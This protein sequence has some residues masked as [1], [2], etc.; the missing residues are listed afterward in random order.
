MNVEKDSL[1]RWGWLMVGLLI[2]AFVS[3]ILNQL[4]FHPYVFPQEYGAVTVIAAMAPVIIYVG[5]WY[6]EDRQSYWRHSRAHIFGDVAFVVLGAVAGAGS[7]LLAVPGTGL[8][9]DLVAMTAGF[10]VGWALF[11]TRNSDLYRSDD[12]QRR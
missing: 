9:Q 7:A 12:D 2:M 8:A 3:N 4:F 6:D 11:Y 10:V 5:I 1:P